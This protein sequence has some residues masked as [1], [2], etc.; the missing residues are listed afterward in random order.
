MRKLRLIW[1]LYILPALLAAWLIAMVYAV[2]WAM[3]GM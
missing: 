1:E 2:F 3:G